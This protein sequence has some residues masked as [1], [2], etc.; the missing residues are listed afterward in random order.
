MGV[1]THAFVNPIGAAQND[2][3]PPSPY[4]RGQSY[5]RGNTVFS[6]WISIQRGVVGWGLLG[7][8]H[9][10]TGSDVRLMFS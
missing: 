8:T 10:I 1:L 7:I 6:S 5:G 2:T 9:Y 3:S 4:E